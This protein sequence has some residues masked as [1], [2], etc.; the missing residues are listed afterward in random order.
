VGRLFLERLR[1][2]PCYG[3]LDLAAVNDLTAFVLAWPIDEYV[4]VYPWIWLPKED[5][6]K[7]SKR[8]NVPYVQWAEQGFLE[9]TPGNVTDWRFVTARI[10]QLA[11]TFEIREIGFDCAGARDTVADLMDD[12][13]QVVDIGQGFLSMSAPS[14]RLQQLV[15][16]KRLVHTGHPILRWNVDCATVDQDAAGN[17]KPIKPDRQKSSKRIDA[18]VA[19]VMAIDCLMKNDANGGM[20]LTFLK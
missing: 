14:K 3:G 4:Y 11:R 1:S 16:S 13:L 7:R 12:G 8:D 10:K 6:H 18:V 17:I 19:A 2:Y 20:E 9:L 5:L 15:L